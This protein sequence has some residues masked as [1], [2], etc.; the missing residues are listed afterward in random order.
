MLKIEILQNE[1]GK[2]I[3]TI[4]FVIGKIQIPIT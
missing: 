2:Q 3:K 1:R 4:M